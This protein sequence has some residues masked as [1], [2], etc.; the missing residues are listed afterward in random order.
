MI[1]NVKTWTD[2]TQEE[3]EELI[4]TSECEEVRKDL[5]D[6]Y[7]DGFRTYF[8]EVL[9]NYINAFVEGDIN[10]M[11][12]FKSNIAKNL[13]F[14]SYLLDGSWAETY[15]KNYVVRRKTTVELIK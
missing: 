12:K 7:E 13:N 5:R 9:D 2:L 3:A 10:K 15:G 6:Y 1:E 8:N 14:N 11:E 4:Y